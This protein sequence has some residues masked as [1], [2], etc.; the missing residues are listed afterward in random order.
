M[1]TVVGLSM[2]SVGMLF[3]AFVTRA[4]GA[5]GIGVYTLMMT[6]YSF[7]VTFATA[8]ISLSVTRLVAA[9]VGDGDGLRVKGILRAAFLYSLIFS[10][11]GSVAL[12]FGA[13]LL[14]MRVLG[15][16]DCAKA[17]RVL[18]L[19]LPPMAASSVIVGYFIGV[20]RVRH[21]ALSQ[22]ASQLF[23]VLLTV[24]LISSASGDGVYDAI[25]ALSLGTLI[26]ELLTFLLLICEYVFDLKKY[27][28]YAEEDTSAKLSKMARHTLPLALSQY[29]RNAL[30]SLEHILIPKRLV[31][32]GQSTAEA[33][34][35]YGILHG[36]ALPTVIFALSPLTSF[37]GLLVP[38]FAECDSLGKYRRMSSIATEALNI[39]LGY[40][41]AVMTVL[42]LFSEELGLVLYG[43]YDAAR[44]IAVLAPV[45]PIMYLDHV[46]DSMLKGVGEQVYSM[47]VNITDSFLSVILVWVLIPPLGIYGY[48]LVI[49][50]MEAY[51]F[52]L[53]FIRLGKRIR[54]RI[55]P[56]RSILLPVISSFAS[57]KLSS[58]IFVG[59][60][61]S[62]GFFWLVMKIVF[63]GAAFVFSMT[64][65][66]ALVTRI[67]PKLKSLHGTEKA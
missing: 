57:V 28:L 30:L 20:K 50:I 1:L 24:A 67:S 55:Y 66:T 34:S 13:D 22:I 14:S 9:S 58:L 40:S 52:I 44:Y 59:T 23:K 39:T 62:V 29:V 45:V 21:N 27:P 15:V 61:K 43:S 16:G 49:I 60:G 31:H 26:T 11:V 48:A 12:F 18:A 35:D 5:E 56:V 51:N 38:E 53:S 47:W 63:V 6:V 32:R 17:F 25:F 3:G 54:F 41:F 37:S 65:L 10:F 46:T 7:A 33:Y 2:R 19:S 8:G 36:M 4:V 64:L 42:C